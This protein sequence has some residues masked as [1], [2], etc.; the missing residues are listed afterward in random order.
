MDLTL[1]TM[2]RSIKALGYEVIGELPVLGI[3][4][5]GKVRE[6]PQYLDEAE[7]LGRRLASLL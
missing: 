7:E 4:H 1:E 3:F 2:H 6:Y 5:K